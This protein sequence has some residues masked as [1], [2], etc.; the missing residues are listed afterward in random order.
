MDYTQIF[1]ILK[2]SMLPNTEVEQVI[3]GLMAIAREKNARM[4]Y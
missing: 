1:I 4:K 3:T 2:I